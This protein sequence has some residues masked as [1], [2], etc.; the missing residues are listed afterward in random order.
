L[1]DIIFDT[2]TTGLDPRED[3]IIELGAVELVNRFPT[4]RTFHHYIN[5]QGRNVDAEAYA[6]H[7]IGTTELAGKPIFQEIADEFLIFIEGA[8]LVAHNAGFDVAFIN[9][10]L[11]RIGAQPVMPQRVIDTLALARRKHPLGPNSLDALCRRYCI[12]NSHRTRHGALLDSELLSEVYLEL[13]GG[14]QAALGLEPLPA[15]EAGALDAG[16]PAGIVIRQ[17]PVALAPRLTESERDAHLLLVA[18]LG[19]K[20]AWLRLD[21]FEAQTTSESLTA[22]AAVSR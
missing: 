15:V 12:D 19:E 22:E 6:V 7:G 9:A 16:A 13:I 20:A 8:N 1:R 5:P 11:A 4:G 21:E 10:E 3:R 2:E 14:R 17:R 18:E